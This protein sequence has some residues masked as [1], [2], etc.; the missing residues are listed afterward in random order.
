MI[1]WEKI[2]TSADIDNIPDGELY[3]E[4]RSYA[5]DDILDIRETL[6]EEDVE[7]ALS[8]QE[9]IP[10]IWGL[11]L[12]IGPPQEGKSLL[13][14]ALGF[15]SKYLF[16]KLA[17][18]DAQPRKAFGRYLP[19]NQD[20]LKE[21][22]ARLELMANGQG[23]VAKDGKWVTPRGE[24]FLRNATVIMDEFGSK[25]MSRLDSPMIE[26]KKTLLKLFPLRRHS[27]TLYLGVGTELK[28]FDRHCFPH[29][30]Y[31]INC[32]RI[33]EPPYD[34]NG[35]GIEIVGR[36][37]R[38]KYREDRDEFM[39]IGE[40]SIIHIDGSSPK[41]YLGGLAYKDIFHTDN[42]HAITASKKMRLEEPKKVK[43]AK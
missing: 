34:P 18:V 2:K 8:W 22:L 14:H 38:V 23:K 4:Y 12:I 29:T 39:P 6:P 16:G 42:V 35:E 5:Q 37:Q 15:D 20:F 1:D 27:Y 28:D 24:V 25:H 43:V 3:D 41:E 33:D 19:F 30:D 36:C 11:A 31:L 17:I 7:R 32:T 40:P 13:A 9:I 26:P 10:N 21:Q